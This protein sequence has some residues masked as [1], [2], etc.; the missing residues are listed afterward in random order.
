[1]LL[2]HP[3]E[4]A[5]HDP[6][7]PRHRRGYQPGMAAHAI[8]V[9]KSDSQVRRPLTCHARSPSLT[10]SQPHTLQWPTDRPRSCRLVLMLTTWRPKRLCKITVAILVGVARPLH[11]PIVQSLVGRETMVR[12]EDG[13]VARLPSGR[14]SHASSYRL[15]ARGRAAGAATG[16]TRF[17]SFSGHVPAHDGEAGST[18]E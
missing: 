15:R 6:V 18:A 13:L 7:G 2:L 1:M 4:A 11:C 5:Y 10:I 14:C 8:E 9:R 17:R 3:V 16:E 12:F